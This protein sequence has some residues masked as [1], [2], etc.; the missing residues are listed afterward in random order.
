MNVY[1]WSIRTIRNIIWMGC[2]FMAKRLI[3]FHPLFNSG[4]LEKQTDAIIIELT[5]THLIDLKSLVR[6]RLPDHFHMKKV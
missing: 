3:L 5:N 2:W 4:I 1:S 6:S